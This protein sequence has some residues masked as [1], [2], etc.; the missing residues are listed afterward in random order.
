MRRA[1]S[2]SSCS[3][4]RLERWI[5]GTDVRAASGASVFTPTSGVSRTLNVETNEAAATAQVP[6]M[7]MAPSLILMPSSESWES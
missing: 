7:S 3:G 4:G 5:A 2:C 1:T 6:Q